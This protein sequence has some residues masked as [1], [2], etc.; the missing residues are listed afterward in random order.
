[1]APT[2]RLLRRVQRWRRP[3]LLG[4]SRAAWFLLN[5]NGFT[6]GGKLRE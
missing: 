2:L 4:V 1:M 3:S 5:L 6:P